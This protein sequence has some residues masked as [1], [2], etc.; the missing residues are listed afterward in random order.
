MNYGT[1]AID[2]SHSDGYVGLCLGPQLK[3]HG[4]PRRVAW[5][6]LAKAGFQNRAMQALAGRCLF[7]KCGALPA[8]SC[9][10]RSAQEVVLPCLQQKVEK[11]HLP[12]ANDLLELVERELAIRSWGQPS[13]LVEG[14]QV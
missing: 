9:L 14:A 8:A 3:S 4:N 12:A 10:L 1:A 13:N 11:I 7:S 2:L 6:C 5:C